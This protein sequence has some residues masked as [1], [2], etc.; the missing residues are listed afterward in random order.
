MQTGMSTKVNGVMTKHRATVFTTTKEAQPT[1][2]IGS[3]TSSMDRVKKHGLMGHISSALINR[4]AKMV[5]A[6]SSGLMEALITVNS[7][8]TT[9]MEKALMSGPTVGSTLANGSR[10]RCTERGRTLGRMDE[11]MRAN[12]RTTSKKARVVL[13]GKMGVFT[14]ALGKLAFK[15]EL[16]I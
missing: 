10:T 1:K 3:T 9:F 2:A 11:N 4:A 6:S 13:N 16:A 5:K 14:R 15:M 7:L 8:T 12:I